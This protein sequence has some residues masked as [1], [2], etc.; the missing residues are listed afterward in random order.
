MV[1]LR[2]ICV[3]IDTPSELCNYRYSKKGTVI[4]YFSY[5]S[6]FVG[7]LHH[8]H[9]LALLYPPTTSLVQFLCVF[10]SSSTSTMGGTH[11]SSPKSV[12]YVVVTRYR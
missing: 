10:S 12:S 1:I 3:A 11:L 4:N 9:L 2:L 8:F 5:Y 6:P 7:A